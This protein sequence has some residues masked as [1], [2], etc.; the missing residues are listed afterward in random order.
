M[1]VETPADPQTGLPVATD[2]GSPV[3]TALGVDQRSL[4][5]RGAN[6]GDADVGREAIPPILRI[7]RRL[8]DLHEAPDSDRRLD[9][10]DLTLPNGHDDTLG[11]ADHDDDVVA[12]HPLQC[13]RG[14]PDHVIAVGFLVQ[15]HEALDVVRSDRIALEGLDTEAGTERVDREG[16][17]SDAVDE[18]PLVRGDLARGSPSGLVGTEV[19]DAPEAV[20]ERDCRLAGQGRTGT[21]RNVD[22][23][24]EV[25]GYVGSEEH[26]DR[27]SPP[28]R[29]GPTLGADPVQRAGQAA[30]AHVDLWQKP[31][32]AVAGTVPSHAADHADGKRCRVHVD[33]LPPVCSAPPAGRK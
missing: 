3:R 11:V 14:E 20:G 8:G 28:V 12:D 16:S 25:D 17:R 5:A 32:E 30:Q 31:L 19:G 10:G 9:L 33:I 21:P 22:R 13:L 27:E 4:T 2:H 24:H 26:P 23:P 1:G 18:P 6:Q 15:S 7:G 29:I